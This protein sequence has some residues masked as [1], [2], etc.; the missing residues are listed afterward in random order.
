MAFGILAW[1]DRDEVAGFWRAIGHENMQVAIREACSLHSGGHLGHQSGAVTRRGAGVGFDHFLEHRPEGRFSRRLCVCGRQSRERSACQCGDCKSEWRH[2]PSSSERRMVSINSGG[3]KQRLPPGNKFF[4]DGSL[5]TW[6]QPA[7]AQAGI[8]GL[9]K[10]RRTDLVREH[11]TGRGG[12]SRAEV[13]AGTRRSD[14]R[15][16]RR[17][18]DQSKARRSSRGKA[19]AS[20]PVLSAVDS[21]WTVT[22][23]EQNEEHIG[24][25]PWRKLIWKH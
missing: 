22:V 4:P 14:C 15:C 18:G 6:K 16:K 8:R 12:G 24:Y 25:E 5:V 9:A 20:S 21:K 17:Q 1:Q 10:G 11:L 2:R 7:H 13:E 3:R 19:T 23:L